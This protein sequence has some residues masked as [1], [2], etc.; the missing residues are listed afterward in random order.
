LFTKPWNDHGNCELPNSYIGALK[1]ILERLA[2]EYAAVAVPM[3]TAQERGIKGGATRALRAIEVKFARRGPDEVERR[4]TD[5]RLERAED[6]ACYGVAPSATILPVRATLEQRQQYQK[7]LEHAQ[8]ALSKRE[9]HISKIEEYGNGPLAQ[10][11]RTSYHWIWRYRRPV[12]RWN[13]PLENP[14]GFY[15]R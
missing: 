3:R 2:P 13:G 4:Q 8:A 15:R 12:A 6:D 11:L 10:T 7:I 5:E 14:L 1:L 9:E